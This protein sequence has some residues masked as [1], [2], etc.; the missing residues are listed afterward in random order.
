VILPTGQY[1]WVGKRLGISRSRRVVKLFTDSDGFVKRGDIPFQIW[2]RGDADLLIVEGSKLSA[3]EIADAMNF[4]TA[5]AKNEALIKAAVTAILRN[6]RPIRTLNAE[7]PGQDIGDRYRQEWR[8]FADFFVDTDIPKLSQ[9]AGNVLLG[10]RLLTCFMPRAYKSFKAGAMLRN[11][12]GRPVY[13]LVSPP[14]PK[15]NETKEEFA[16]RYERDYEALIT[17]AKKSFVDII[18]K[19][20]DP[21]MTATALIDRGWMDQKYT[22]EE[23]KEKMQELLEKPEMLIDVVR[24]KEPV[25]EVIEA[26]GFTLVRQ[27]IA[28]IDFDE[29]V[30]AAAAA[31]SAEPNE[32]IA[33]I[34]SAETQKEVREILTPD[35]MQAGREGYDLASII[36]AAQDDK[37]GSI[38]VNWVPPGS[39]GITKAAAIIGTDGT[40]INKGG[41]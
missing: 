39:D 37:T 18:I 36:A 25:T 30:K 33:Q 3:K 24:V 8:Q 1:P 40:A 15:A 26:T 35:P 12:N 27:S 28:D 14:K 41:K 11:R 32:R 6:E 9:V 21:K 22:V 20:G 29:K 34:A 19:Q 23:F 7:N 31:A 13:E 38:R 16:E 17:E 2:D 4:V 5:P 10:E